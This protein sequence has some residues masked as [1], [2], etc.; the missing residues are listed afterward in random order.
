MEMI[1]RACH[2]WLN[3][4][5]GK[6]ISCI[7]GVFLIST[8]LDVAQA[9]LESEDLPDRDGIKFGPMIIH[10][11]LKSGVTFDTNIDIQPYSLTS[12]VGG[13]LKGS[14]D[15]WKQFVGGSVSNMVPVVYPNSK[16]K[17]ANEIRENLFGYFVVVSVFVLLFG[18]NH[19]FS[20]ILSYVKRMNA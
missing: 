18:M 10:A 3:Q 9:Q 5:L 14:L 19:A 4:P 7:L 6:L 17:I 1:I 2:Y 16:I 15:I 8:F 13:S 12:F 11:A 20:L